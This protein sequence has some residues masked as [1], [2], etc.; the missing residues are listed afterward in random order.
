MT[1]NDKHPLRLTGKQKK[2]LRG[3]GHHLEPI[4]YVGREGL[5]VSLI[6]S[7]SDA[8]GVHELIKVK[9]GRNCPV[10]KKDAAEQLAFK[11]DSALVQ[12]IGK[13]VLLY[14][15]NPDLPKEKRI[16]V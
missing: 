7:T 14:Q 12:L 10:G 4:V 11:T 8:L 9:L 3:L 1:D 13:T 2:L 15:P 6:N 5:S 16:S